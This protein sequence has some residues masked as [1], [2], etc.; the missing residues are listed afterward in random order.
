MSPLN[1]DTCVVQQSCFLS[2]LGHW[3]TERL[4]EDH[5]FRPRELGVCR[6]DEEAVPL[7]GAV[8]GLREEGRAPG[9]LLSGVSVFQT[10]GS[11]LQGPACPERRVSAACR[12]IPVSV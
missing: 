12:G 4:T 8:H 2:S 5:T 9:G 11:P 7:A 10:L 3:A 6:A 1:L